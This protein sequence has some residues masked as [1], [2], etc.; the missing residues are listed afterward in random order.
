MCGDPEQDFARIRAF[1]ADKHGRF[2]D[3][4]GDIRLKS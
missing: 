3:K 1:Y 4:A 2:P